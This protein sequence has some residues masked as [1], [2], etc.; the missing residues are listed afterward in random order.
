MYS[1]SRHHRR[2]L[3]SAAPAAAHR[4][5]VATSDAAPTHQASWLGPCLG[6]GSEIPGAEAHTEPTRFPGK[7]HRA[8][9]C[10]SART[11]EVYFNITPERRWTNRRGHD[12]TARRARERPPKKFGGPGSHKSTQQPHPAEGA[13]RRGKPPR[14]GGPGR[15]R[16]SAR[17][18]KSRIP[19]RA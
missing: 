4:M 8:Q 7:I 11:L 16:E 17:P 10:S 9:P 5:K 14:T 3:V 12:K 15:A 2:S 18:Q 1:R 19:P 13:K 6:L